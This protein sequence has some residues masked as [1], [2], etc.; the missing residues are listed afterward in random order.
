[1]HVQTE[2]VKVASFEEVGE[3]WEA[4][5]AE[6]A[7]TS[8]F[9]SWSWVGC[10]AEER[11]PDPVLLRCTGAGG[12]TLGLALF[13][14]RAGRLC[15]SESGDVRMDAP[16]IEHNAP[17]TV[18]GTTPALRLALLRGAWR[19][20]GVSCLVLSGVALADVD[21]VGGTVWQVQHRPAPCLDLDA[22]RAG[23]HGQDWIAALSANTRYQIR[24]SQ[25][26]Y[27][28][29]ASGAP[30]R[31]EAAENETQAAAWLDGLAALHGATWRS[32]GQDGAFAD[33]FAQRFHHALVRRALARGQLDLLRIAAG[34][35]LVI[36]FLYN[37]RHRG[38]VFA[39]QS[40]LDLTEANAH[41]K[42]G[43]TCHALAVQRSLD[44]GDLVYDFLAGAQRYKRSLANA[45]AMLAWAEL[46]PAW[47]PRGIF[48][49]A[50]RA[51]KLRRHHA[52]AALS[53]P[54]GLQAE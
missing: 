30:L 2:I 13:N 21:A 1:M 44:R 18:D 17:L 37:L 53:G 14:R 9:Q 15:L 34:P 33:P 46:V 51:L 25:R 47:S 48:A 24:R 41:E 32:R 27:R 20:P 23:G 40:G 39:Y 19:V 4:L 43:L 5:E 38:R 22:V 35:E 28:A 45:E 12:R 49:R 42:P 29:R 26:R 54:G 16:F 3:A 7:G 36:G 11:Y 10:L 6:G 50:A 52:G 8:I 31:L